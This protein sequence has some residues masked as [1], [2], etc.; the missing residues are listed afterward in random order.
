M[1]VYPALAAA[2]LWHARPPADRGLAGALGTTRAHLLALL[3]DP[4][5]TTE[6]GRRLG[7]SAPTISEHLRALYAAGLVT[8]ARAGRTVLYVRS[9]TGTGLFGPGEP[10]TAPQLSRCSE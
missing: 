8:R 4:A 1:G 10:P 7:L 6:L 2:T 9:A 3:R 5:T